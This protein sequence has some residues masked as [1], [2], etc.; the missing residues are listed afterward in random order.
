MGA[1]VVQTKARKLRRAA[2]SGVEDE[3][4]LSHS[5]SGISTTP[6]HSALEMGRFEPRTGGRLQAS[7]A[8]PSEASLNQRVPFL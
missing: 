2:S 6:T 5:T 7:S 8:F 4:M 3:P 1:V